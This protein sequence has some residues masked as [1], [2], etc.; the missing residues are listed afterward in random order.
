MH[1]CWGNSHVVLYEGD[2][3]CHQAPKKYQVYEQDISPDRDRSKIKCFNYNTIQV[4]LCEQSR[5]DITGVLERIES[6]TKTADF[7]QVP[8]NLRITTQSHQPIVL[9]TLNKRCLQKRTSVHCLHL[10][11]VK[12]TL[13]F[14]NSQEIHSYVSDFFCPLPNFSIHLETVSLF[15]ITMT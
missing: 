8:M 14:P 4:S 12:Y 2:C 10:H 1:T 7:S 11:H 15:L 5:K 13:C 6:L 3:S 9:F